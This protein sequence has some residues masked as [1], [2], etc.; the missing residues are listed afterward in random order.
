M[1]N[2]DLAAGA[3]YKRED[4]MENGDKPLSSEQLTFPQAIGVSDWEPTSSL[5][6]RSI[7]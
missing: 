2:H 5:Q 1:P 7:L 4:T 3:R 6:G